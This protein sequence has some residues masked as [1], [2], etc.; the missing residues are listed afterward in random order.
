MAVN[1]KKILVPVDFSAVSSKSIEYAV[2]MAESFSSEVLL[3]HVVEESTTM[4]LG[5]NDPVNIKGRWEKEE[6]SEACATLNELATSLPSS[7]KVVTKVLTGEVGSSIVACLIAEK[8]DMLIMGA[9]GSSGI[10]SDWL[11][12]V[13]YKVSKKAPC[14]VLM[15]RQ[16]S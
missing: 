2:A 10:L 11:G 5:L 1:V 14:P 3:L 7:L 9:H 12:G 4:G 6:F 15:V 8:C 13:A 16:K